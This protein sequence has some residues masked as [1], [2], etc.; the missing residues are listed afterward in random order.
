[1]GILLETALY[2]D[3]GRDDDMEAVS[4]THLKPHAG[5]S[6]EGESTA[7]KRN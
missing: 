7:Q 1:M 2:H 3:I 4:Y 5:T 6:P